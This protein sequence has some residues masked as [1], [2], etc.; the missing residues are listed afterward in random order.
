MAGRNRE[1]FAGLERRTLL[2]A[3][4]VLAFALVLAY[5]LPALDRAVPYRA[6]VAPGD[7]FDMGLGVTLAPAAGWR[8]EGGI[9]TRE[10]PITP[11]DSIGGAVRIVRGDVAFEART[12]PYD[13]D[14]AALLAQL[15]RVQASDL[16]AGGYVRLGRPHAIRTRHGRH[17]L[18]Q[19]YRGRKGVGVVAAYAFDRTGVELACFGKRLPFAAARDEVNAMLRSVDYS[20]RAARA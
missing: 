11:V 2:P 19:R 6:R 13:G 8:I 9:L 1:R 7:V 15:E 10:Q 4:G 17:G 20:A 14:A 18:E 3:V 16:R 12:G 5:A